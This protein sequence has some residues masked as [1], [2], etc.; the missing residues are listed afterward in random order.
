MT[1]D[2]FSQNE[3]DVDVHKLIVQYPIDENKEGSDSFMK[4]PRMMF[5]ATG[6]I[7]A[8][9]GIIAGLLVYFL[10][11]NCHKKLHSIKAFL[12]LF[13]IFNDDQWT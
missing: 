7:M 13:R 12:R 11:C 2:F 1:I 9:V 5:R 10:F 4:L 8:T 6:A 3:Q